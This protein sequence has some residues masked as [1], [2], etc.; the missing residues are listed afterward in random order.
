M[1]PVLLLIDVIIRLIAVLF[2]VLWW[3]GIYWLIL[4]MSVANLIY[5]GY[6]KIQDI[7]PNAI[8]SYI[9][10]VWM[11]N[12]AFYVAL[13]FMVLTIIQNICRIIMQKPSFNIFGKITM[14]INRKKV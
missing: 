12:I 1:N 4:F 11:E 8:G 14:L 7:S 5:W 2:R 13:V 10:P 6:A 3:I 9:P